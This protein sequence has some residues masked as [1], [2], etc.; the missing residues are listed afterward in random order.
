MIIQKSSL[1]LNKPILICS[2]PGLGMV[3]NYVINYLISQLK[4]KIYAELNIDEYYSPHNIL[5]QNGIISFPQSVENNFYYHKTQE[6][7]ILLF[8]SDMQPQQNFMYKIAKEIV[9]FA[10]KLEVQHII[11]FAG[12]PTNIIHTDKP[13][14]FVAQ[15]SQNNN[16]EFNLPLM[17]YGIVEG[18]NGVI[19]G[20]AKEVNIN[21]SCILA[22]IPVYTIDMDNPQTALRVLKLLDKLFLLKL[23]FGKVNSDIVNMEEKI[24]VV[25]E[26]LNQK[27]QKLFTQFDISNHHHT[28]NK[29][30]VVN[31]NGISFEEL[32]KRIKFSLPESAKNK[33]DELFK[34]CAQDIKYAKE[35][36]DELDRWGVYKDYED[37][38]LNLF[39][40]NKKKKNGTDS[41][42]EN[43]NNKNSEKEEGE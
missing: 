11:T 39:L 8:L 36:K 41:N 27:A 33:I 2:W 31:F 6:Y 4:P 37:K 5:I 22:E 25:F 1:K 18:M 29:Y 14:L 32:K 23:D 12:M 28:K 19:L 35:L 26:E 17:G 9:S 40:K 30:D 13:K 42:S 3:G 21:A 7:D 24:K 16:L 38:F 34:L 10:N 15:T 20:C 43:K